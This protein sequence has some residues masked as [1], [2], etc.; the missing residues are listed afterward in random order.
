MAGLIPK[1]FSVVAEHYIPRD[2]DLATV[3]VR[4]KIPLRCSLL[5]TINTQLR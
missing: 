4:T 2:V 5:G 1:L 3:T